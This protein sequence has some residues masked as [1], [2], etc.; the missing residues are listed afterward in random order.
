MQSAL[1]LL[2]AVSNRQFRGGTPQFPVFAKAH[3]TGMLGVT[4][5]LSPKRESGTVNDRLPFRGLSES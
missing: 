4:F 1:Y 2:K 3:G 5:E